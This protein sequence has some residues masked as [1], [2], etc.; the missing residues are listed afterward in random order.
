MKKEAQTFKCTE[1]SIMSTVPL[2][3]NASQWGILIIN[4]VDHNVYAEID[5]FFNWIIIIFPPLLYFSASGK[6]YVP[7]TLLRT[8]TSQPLFLSRPFYLLSRSF[9]SP[10]QE[11]WE[12]TDDCERSSHAQPRSD[13]LEMTRGLSVGDSYWGG[14]WRGPWQR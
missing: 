4:D 8:A 13:S 5:I 6:F 11:S 9:I 3:F 10:L 7:P 14:R 1:L 2:Q 12:S